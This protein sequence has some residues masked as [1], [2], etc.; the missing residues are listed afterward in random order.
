MR[1]SGVFIT[2]HVPFVAPG[3]LPCEPQPLPA[4]HEVIPTKRAAQILLDRIQSLHQKICCVRLCRPLPPPAHRD[5]A[6]QVSE[7]RWQLIPPLTPQHPK[8]FRTKPHRRDRLSPPP[9][10]K[11][12]GKHHQ[13]FSPPSRERGSNP[14]IPT[15]PKFFATAPSPARVALP[16][17]PRQPLRVDQCRSRFLHR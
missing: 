4:S 8:V 12:A 1:T 6:I 15:N 2:P 5:L 3:E 13:D 14:C 7:A 16:L 11:H 10:E 9:A 17:E